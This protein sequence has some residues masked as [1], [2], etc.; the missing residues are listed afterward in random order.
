MFP[1]KTQSSAKRRTDYRILCGMS[2]M[3]IKKRTG[4]KTDPCG[5]PDKTGTGSEARPSKPSIAS[6]C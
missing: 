1:Y 2:L 6:F 4:T 5:T 3:N